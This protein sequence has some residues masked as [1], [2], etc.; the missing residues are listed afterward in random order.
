MPACSN[1]ARRSWWALIMFDFFL[2]I[3]ILWRIIGPVVRRPDLRRHRVVRVPKTAG[4][5]RPDAA[6]FLRQSPRV[7]M[8]GGA[9]PC[10][11]VRVLHLLPSAF[12]GATIV[13]DR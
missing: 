3:G 6:R 4:C 7:R 5:A 12:L 1:M 10:S 13:D 2:G 8:I 9:K 11:S